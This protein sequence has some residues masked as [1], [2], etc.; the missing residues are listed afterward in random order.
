[1]HVVEKTKET[2]KKLVKNDPLVK[3][4]SPE[5]EDINQDDKDET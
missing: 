2:L 5:E 1:M 3:K 4:M